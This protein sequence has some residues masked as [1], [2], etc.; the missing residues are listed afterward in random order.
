MVEIELTEHEKKALEMRH[1]RC[2][3]VREKDRIKAVLLSSEKW[4]VEMIAQA[5]RISESSFKRH[6]SDY[7]DKN[8]LSTA[9][10]GSYS[11]L[12]EAQTDEVI[13]HTAI[14]AEQ[15]KGRKK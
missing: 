6:V 13:E 9:N 5:L 10:G 4:T 3:D 15:S 8:K 2:K 11:Y 14:P 7:K 12:S 1:R